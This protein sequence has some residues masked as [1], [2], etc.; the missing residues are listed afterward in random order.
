MARNPIIRET[1]PQGPAPTH[2][3]TPHGC[4]A[5]WVY[6]G[7]EGEDESG[8]HVEIVERVRCRRCRPE[9]LQS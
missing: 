2:E 1:T 8:E 3:E 5:G 7:F 4:Y 6:L 9:D